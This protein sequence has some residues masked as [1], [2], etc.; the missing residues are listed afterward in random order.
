MWILGIKFRVSGLVVDA[1]IEPY[2]QLLFVVV[3]LGFLHACMS[4]Y[5]M[6]AGA[7]GGQNWVS[8][9]LGLKFQKDASCHVGARTRTGV[10]WTLNHP[11]SP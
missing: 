4:V 7:F 8:D 9:P 5:V 10:L 1:L 11:S 2:C 3:V 6:C